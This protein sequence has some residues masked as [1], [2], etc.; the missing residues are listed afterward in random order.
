VFG[1]NDNYRTGK[2]GGE[3]NFLRTYVGAGVRLTLA[4]ARKGVG[5]SPSAQDD[6]GLKWKRLALLLE[7]RGVDVRMNKSL[8]ASFSSEK[9]GAYLPYTAAALPR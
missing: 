6:V 5:P 3:G 2:T 8:F 4:V 9:E 1:I 7:G